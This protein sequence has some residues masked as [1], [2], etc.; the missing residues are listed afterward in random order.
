MKHAILLL[1]HKDFAHL[2]RFVDYFDEDFLLYIHVDRKSKISDLDIATLLAKKHVVA[3]YRKYDIN[4]GGYNFLK[5]EHY[6]LEKAVEDHSCDYYHFF[7]G[8]DFPIKRLSAFKQ[9]MESNQG[10][11]YVS[12]MTLP[13]E[14]WEQGTFDRFRYYHLN[15]WFD[16]RTPRGRQ[17]LDRSFHFQQKHHIKRHHLR[18]FDRLYGGS[19]WIS[20]TKECAEYVLSYTRNHPA[21]YRRLRYTFS[22][23]ETYFHTLILNSAFASKV[24]NNNFRYVLWKYENGSF[25]ANLNEKQFFELATTDD[26]FARKFEYSLSQRL[27]KQIEYYL[28][29]E[30]TFAI[31]EEGY[32]QSRSFAGH[33]F[34]NWLSEVLGVLLVDMDVDSVVDLGCGPGWYVEALRRKGFSAVGYD[35]NSH[36]GEMSALFSWTYPCEQAN[37]I[38]ELISDEPFDL[39]LCLEVGEHI[40]MQYEDVLFQNLVRNSGRYIIMS[41]AVEG[42]GGIGH[43]NC[44]SNQYVIDKLSSLGFYENVSAKNFLRRSAKLKW[45]KNTIMVFQKN[46]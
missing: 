28:L 37:L 23:E 41:W 32:W 21:F 33:Y 26:F 10:K 14:V 1:C 27:L 15:D 7:S 39:V 36:V 9:Y 40:P 16:P 19:N 8:Q 6:L 34:D 2:N 13:N 17:L 44:R 45:F 20:I 5:A 25:P 24:D 18:P 4:W 46:R 43:L 35:G 42:Q 22:P 29:P 3:I 38:E 11:E 31:S 30:E 12:Y